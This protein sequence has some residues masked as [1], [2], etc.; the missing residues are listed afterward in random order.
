MEGIDEYIRNTQQEAEDKRA[1]FENEQRN[2]FDRQEALREQVITDRRIAAV[3]NIRRIRK[4][5]ISRI[6][7]DETEWQG[8]AGRW[9][10]TAGARPSSRPRRRRGGGAEEVQEGELG[11]PA[12]AGRD[13]PRGS[14]ARRRRPDL[15]G[16]TR[17]RPRTPAVA[18]G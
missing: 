15:R 6:K 9:L 1:G 16:S 14:P 17:A 11:I 7:A 2:F 13:R 10:Y 12:R 4:E 8:E 3:S 5:T 18:V